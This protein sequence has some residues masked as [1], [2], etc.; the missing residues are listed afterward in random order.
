[1]NLTR[2]QNTG[3]CT[4]ALDLQTYSGPI[5]CFVLPLSDQFDLILGDDWCNETGCEISYRDHCLRCID[6]DG[7][8]HNLII[9]SDQHQVHC[10]VVSA[11]NLNTE[12]EEGD[13]MYVVDVTCIDEIPILNGLHWRNIYSFGSHA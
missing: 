5:E 8:H 1:V 13:V 12:M 9:Q 11:V 2:C 7:R 10:P 4:L 3:T 6:H